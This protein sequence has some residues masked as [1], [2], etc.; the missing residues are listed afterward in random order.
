[1][2]AEYDYTNK[3]I[4]I[5]VWNTDLE[6]DAHVYLGR[7]KKEGQNFVF[8]NGE[9]GWRISLNADKLK[10]LKLVIPELKEIF[11]N[12]ELAI[13]LSMKGLPDDPQQNLEQT[14]IKWH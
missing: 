7:I 9:K 6:N 13:V 12:A 3:S 4:A 8:I 2:Q 1:M 11:L 14:G 5:L 10:H